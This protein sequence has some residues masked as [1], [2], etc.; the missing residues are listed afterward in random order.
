MEKVDEE[1]YSKEVILLSEE[2]NQWF[3]KELEDMDGDD[4]E[5]LEDVLDEKTTDETLL[6][7]RLLLWS[8]L[9]KMKNDKDPLLV[10]SYSILTQ[11]KQDFVNQ[12][13]NYYCSQ[14]TRSGQIEGI[15]F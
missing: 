5:P 15:S 4:H 6:N 11:R 3:L 10:L 8:H 2:E 1:D 14:K 9:R 12:N 7:T 13:I